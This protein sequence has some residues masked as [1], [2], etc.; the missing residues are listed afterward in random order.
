MLP[1]KF[2]LAILKSDVDNLDIDKLINVPS[3]LDILK[4]KVDKLDIGK[5][6]S[7]PVDLSRLSDEVKK[8][9]AKK[10]EYDELVKNVNA[11]DTRGL[12]KK[13]AYDTTINEI[14]DKIPNVTG[15]ATTTS[16]NAIKSEIPNVFFI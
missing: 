15:L 11:I 4:S 3:G 8:E 7:T 13:T 1:K 2:D 12:V 10:T 5:L 16:L 6:K 14:K 9:V